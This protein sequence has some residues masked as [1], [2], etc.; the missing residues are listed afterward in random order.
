MISIPLGFLKAFLCFFLD[1]LII[2][3]SDQNKNKGRWQVEEKTT[4]FL[5]Q[6]YTYIWIFFKKKKKSI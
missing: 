4:T 3:Q 1:F 5:Q 6:V 2:E